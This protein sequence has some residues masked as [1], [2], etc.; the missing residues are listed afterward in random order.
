MLLNPREVMEEVYHL[1]KDL[2]LTNCIFRSNH[3]SNYAPLAAQLGKEKERLL[4]DI[5]GFLAGQ[6]NFKPEYFRG[7]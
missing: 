4:S 5:E 2:D 1:V 3:A 6:N 7:L